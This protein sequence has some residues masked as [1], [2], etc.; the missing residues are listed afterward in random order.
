[1]TRL[2]RRA[3]DQGWTV[4]ATA[5]PAPADLAGRAFPASVPGCVHTDLMAAGVIPDPLLDTN[6]SILQWIGLTDWQYAANFEW[7]PPAGAD[8]HDLVFTGL[9]TVA[10]ITLNEHRLGATANMHRTYRF[11]V[12]EA[13]QPGTNELVVAFRSPVRYAD[14]QSVALGYRPHVNH[15]P[16]NALRKMAC[17]FGWD[18]GPDT[19]TSGIWRPVWLES[20]GST[21]LGTVRP[22]VTVS[23]GQGCVEVIA[24]VVYGGAVA[25]FRLTATVSGHGT[26]ASASVALADGATIAHLPVTVDH[27]QLWWPRGYGEQPLYDVRLVLT[28]DGS[29]EEVVD[30]WTSRIGF[31]QVTLD[32]TPD[33]VGTPFTLVINGCPVWVKGANWIPDDPFPHRVMPARY[34]Q[35][36]TQAESANVNLLRVWGGGMYEADVFYDLCDERGLLVWQDFAFACAAYA[37]EQP[38]R[39]EVEAEARDNVT[40]LAPHPSLVVWN[41]SN[42]SLQGMRD[43]HFT[44]RSQGRTTGVGYFATVLPGIVRELHPGAEYVPSSPWSGAWPVD[45]NADQND[46][47]HGSMHSWDVWNC[48]DYL[49]Y[50][51]SVPRFLSEFGWQAPP[52]WSTLTQALH[53]APLTPE[54]PGMLA[55][56]KAVSG[57]DK[58]TDGLLPHM[59]IPDA[60]TDWHWAMQLNQAH[61]V[62][63][64][65]EHLRSHA[66][67]CMGVIV[68]QLN[69]CW[70]VVSW[71][72][73]DGYGVPKPLLYAVKHAFADRLVTVQP[74]PAGL[75]AA[76]SNDTETRW[77]GPMTVRRLRFDGTALASGVFEADAAPR[78]VAVVP[79]PATLAQPSDP[80]RELITVT[81]GDQRGL[82]YFAEPRD[83]A[84]QPARLSTSLQA[85]EDAE[86]EAWVV[87]VTADVL[88]R[89]LTILADIVH[90][91]A[92]ADDALVTLLPGESAKFRVALP[93]GISPDGLLSPTVLRS[94]N[95]LTAGGRPGQ[96]T[97]TK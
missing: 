8:H 27:P 11:P 21:R 64:A 82:W 51:D 54:S 73:V 60:M 92:V 62:Q 59:R 75:V 97:D 91:Q 50:R 85:V 87:T 9:D 70:P 35:R 10:T 33:D 56:Q 49:H 83:Q 74:R 23:P 41:G 40:R 65:I 89:D 58:L 78:G 52:A 3:L 80:A 71:S 14:E 77:V 34:R 29:P 12:D 42:E 93:A 22:V 28:K 55:H 5:G 61:A 63:T 94:L 72:A 7:T 6:E 95:D 46:P 68:W 1:M 30:S 43:W 2:V 47:D 81:C 20:W 4:R 37:E 16:Y 48:Q 45:P 32:R 26:T 15:H 69:D 53:D 18:W 67:R 24:E 19:A 31:R 39:S 79:L 25:P 88:V 84:L 90:P 96:T 38:L 86:E 36:I 17:S 13:L 66:P 44:R 76:L 57:F